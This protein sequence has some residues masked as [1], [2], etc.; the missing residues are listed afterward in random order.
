MTIS[1]ALRRAAPRFAAIFN[2]LRLVVRRVAGTRR[3]KP[4]IDR[5]SDHLRRDIGFSP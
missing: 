1:T 2:L 4:R 5:L 3:R